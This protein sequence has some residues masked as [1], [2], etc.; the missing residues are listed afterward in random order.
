MR[1]AP[2][3]VNSLRSRNDRFFA[4]LERHEPDYLCLQELKLTEALFPWDA[5]KA[6]GYAASVFGQK[7]YN[8]VA[9]V[10]AAPA[11]DIRL[12]M[13]DGVEDPEARFI[14]ARFGDLHVISVYVPNGR[15]PDHPAYGYKLE[16]LRRLRGYLASR[17]KPSEKILVCGDYNVAPGELDVARPDEWAASVLCR[18]DARAALADLRSWGLVDIFRQR[19]PDRR[20]YSWWDYRM[21]GFPKGNGLRIDHIL[22][23]ASIAAAATSAWIDR[24]ERKGKKPSDHAPVVADFG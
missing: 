15:T 2:W 14:A 5:V 6:A 8:G 23:T 18:A 1:I 24:D 22:G 11:D 7:T 16:W 4:W 17:H 19:N 13:G 21:L 3:N 12:G 10:S 20:A 9:I